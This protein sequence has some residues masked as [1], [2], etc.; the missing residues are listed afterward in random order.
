MYPWLIA[1]CRK[2]RSVP[3]IK[4]DKI[5]PRRDDLS[6]KTFQGLPSQ[7][8]ILSHWHAISSIKL[9]SC[10]LKP[11]TFILV[12]IFSLCYSYWK[13]LPISRLN[14]FAA[15]SYSFTLL[16]LPFGVTTPFPS[17]AFT[18]RDVFIGRKH[19]PLS[20]LILL[21]QTSQILSARSRKTCCP[22]L[23]SKPGSSLDSPFLDAGGRSYA[24]KFRGS[25]NSVLYRVIY[26]PSSCFS[27]S[28][29]QR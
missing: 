22:D 3:C 8:F 17:L 19:I 12:F 14:I 2:E 24:E 23:W 1:W 27:H 15:S 25:L 10:V 20:S 7:L 18:F 6:W 16:R 13:D 21:N 26:R 11:V 4:M 9:W 28:V 29:C 5:F